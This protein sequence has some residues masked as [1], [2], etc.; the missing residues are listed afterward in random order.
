MGGVRVSV[1]V[2]VL[3][4]CYGSGYLVVCVFLLWIL[5]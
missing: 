3:I 1:G 5:V 4:K 2:F